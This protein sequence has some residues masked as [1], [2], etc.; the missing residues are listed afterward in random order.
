MPQHQWLDLTEYIESN[1]LLSDIKLCIKRFIRRG[2]GI[3]ISV[4]RLPVSL[5]IFRIFFLC[6]FFFSLYF[7]L[8]GI[9]SCVCVNVLCGL[10]M[11][12]TEYYSFNDF[13]TFRQLQMLTHINYVVKLVYYL[14]I[15][16]VAERFSFDSLVCVRTFFVSFLCF[17]F[18]V[19]FSIVRIQEEKR[20]KKT[21]TKSK[22]RRL[23]KSNTKW[24]GTRRLCG[25][26][27]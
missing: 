2:H 16:H 24:S 6:M 15:H 8:V 18:S 1:L 11:Y 22:P 7:L 23:L 21:K 26:I 9:F 19:S 10:C 27:E 13:A 12:S 5:V 25:L 20:T 4:L 17:L 14:C 3:G